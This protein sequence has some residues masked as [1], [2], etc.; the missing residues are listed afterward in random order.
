MIIVMIMIII[1]KST[2]QFNKQNHKLRVLVDP[3]RQ[4]YNFD[5]NG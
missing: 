3:E 2:K 5:D 4:R 1:I